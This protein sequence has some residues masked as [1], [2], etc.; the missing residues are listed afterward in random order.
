MLQGGYDHR[1][2]CTTTIV[3]KR[4]WERTFLH[5]MYMLVHI[6]IMYWQVDNPRQENEDCIY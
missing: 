6:T 1:E 4:R 3:Y 2:H 5:T